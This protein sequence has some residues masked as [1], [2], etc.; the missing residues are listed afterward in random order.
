MGARFR[1]GLVLG[2]VAIAVGLLDLRKRALAVVQRDRETPQRWLSA[3]PTIWAVRN[4]SALGTGLGTRIGF[5]LWYVVP[6][7]A[8]LHGSVEAGALVY[9]TYGFVR[10]MWVWPILLWVGPRHGYDRV[11]QWFLTHRTEARKLAA[12]QLVAVGASAIL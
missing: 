11:A 3:G 8:L 10:A 4:G 1:I 5:W 9:G 2:P 7:A 6:A 12:V